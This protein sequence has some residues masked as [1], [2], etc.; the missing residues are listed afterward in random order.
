MFYYNMLCGHSN[1]KSKL[2]QS[3]RRLSDLIQI[4]NKAKFT[5]LKLSLFCPFYSS[6]HILNDS[7]FSMRT[8]SNMGT[9]LKSP[10]IH[11]IFPSYSLSA[12][13]FPYPSPFLPLHINDSVT[14]ALNDHPHNQSCPAEGTVRPSG[15]SE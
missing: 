7:L 6:L 15:T 5:S 12:L 10:F 13:Y 1:K 3:V 8:S 14:A 4:Q 9:L 11:I 2:N